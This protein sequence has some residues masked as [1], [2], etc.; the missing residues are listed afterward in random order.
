MSRRAAIAVQSIVGR[1]SSTP[2]FFASIPVRRA[3]RPQLTAPSEILRGRTRDR[4]RFEAELAVVPRAYPHRIDPHDDPLVHHHLDERPH[5]F[6]VR[7]L[8]AL[9]DT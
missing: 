3:R 1:L 7:P 8:V 4:H 2:R 9:E 6:G 5:L